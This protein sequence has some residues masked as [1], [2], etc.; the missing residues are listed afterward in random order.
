MNPDDPNKQLVDDLPITQ[1]SVH[2]YST[3]DKT[4]DNYTQNRE[5]AAN[6]IRSQIDNIISNQNDSTNKTNIHN[7]YFR[8][9]KDHVDP[10]TEKWRE[11][12]SAWQN[13][14]KKYYE[15]YYLHNLKKTQTNFE[16]QYKNQASQKE[17]SQ[18]EELFDLR[19]RLIGK[20]KK[21]ATYV[22]KSRH[23]LPIIAGLVAVMLFLFLQYNQLIAANIMSY[24]SPGNIDPQNII[25]DPNSNSPV[26][27]E[28]KLI[29]PKINIDV[30]VIYD[31]SN[32]YD[33]Q[34]EAMGR[35]VAQ[36]AIP[37]ANS[38]PGELGNTVIAGHS[39]SD[40]FDYGK[41]KFIFAQLEKLEVGDTIYANYNSVRYT[42]IVTKKEVVKPSE[43]DKLVY[44]TDTPILTLITCTPLGTAINRLLVTAKQVSPDPTKATTV[45][46]KPSSSETKSIPG[47]PQTLLEKLF[48]IK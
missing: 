10:Q 14:Y 20:V 9:H 45:E 11:Y 3:A 19:Q 29:I 23:F 15:G 33:T 30:P 18:E 5:A 16:E 47:T 36:F 44:E 6:V 43:V 48:G 4:T 40:L 26:G 2:Y 22:R 24:I 13:Y 21:S 41:Y 27:P 28:P 42:Y 38:H 7:P 8:D 35:G 37:G 32:D 31:I 17:P 25:L 34:M 39:S 1:K 46:Q 12:H